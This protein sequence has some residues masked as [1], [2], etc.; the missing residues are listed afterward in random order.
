MPAPSDKSRS[1]P[2]AIAAHLEDAAIE[3]FPGSRATVR[4]TVLNASDADAELRLEA[5]G[6]P[7]GWIK[8]AQLSLALPAQET[9]Q[10]RMLIKPE[11][12]PEPLPQTFP[13]SISVSRLDAPGQPVILRG[14]VQLGGFAGLRADIDPPLIADGGCVRVTLR[15]QGNETL[16]LSLHGQDAGGRLAYHFDQPRLSLPPGNRAQINAQVRARRHWLGSVRH[17]P[18]VIAVTAES[19]AGYLVPLSA[20]LI[21]KPRLSG[22]LAALLLA[23]ILAAAVAI[24]LL[25]YGPAL[26]S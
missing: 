15:N 5:T 2:P 26:P 13:L 25:A 23:I 21:V 17:A 9:T 19:A 11:R 24:A 4:V 3:L 7:A 6:L 12:Q 20:S 16:Q 10:L 22:P 14:S 18:F 8:H 1:A